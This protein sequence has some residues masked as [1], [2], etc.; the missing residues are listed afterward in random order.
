M[1]P[2]VWQWLIGLVL[3]S[4]LLGWLG[5]DAFVKWQRRRITENT[6][7]QRT[8][9]G[10]PP[11]L[12][13]VLERPFFTVAIGLGVSGGVLPA[14]FIWATLKYY[15]NWQRR[16]AMQDKPKFL[17]RYMSAD[18]IPKDPED[19][20]DILNAL[21]LSSLLGSVVSLFFALTG[22]YICR[23]DEGHS[24]VAILMIAGTCIGVFILRRLDRRKE[25]HQ[26][27]PTM[28]PEQNEAT[29]ATQSKQI[30]K[31]KKKSR[32]RTPKKKTP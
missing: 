23:G 14:M 5:T 30:K 25:E 1:T 12:N 19:R 4:G 15:V 6:W 17:E 8:Y 11:W 7:R 29:E 24:S 9:R 26:A 32:K 31:S 2:A 28:Q 21:G 13:G 20:S 3:V 16:Q 18:V 27:T 10:L 22:G